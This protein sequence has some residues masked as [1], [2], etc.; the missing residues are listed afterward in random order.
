MDL[1]ALL[2][3]LFPESSDENEASGDEVLPEDD[4]D[5][6]QILD[7]SG[8]CNTCSHLGPFLTD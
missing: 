1:F 2:S 5:V 7:R 3:L 6:S 8:V 4:S